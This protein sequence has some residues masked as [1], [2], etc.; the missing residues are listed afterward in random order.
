LRHKE[1][2]PMTWIDAAAQMAPTPTQVGLA[3]I[4]VRDG[5][6]LP[7]GEARKV[8]DRDGASPIPDEVAGTI[9]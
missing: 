1:L 7:Q 4:G 5:F 6:N 2:L 3:Q 9:Y 8:W